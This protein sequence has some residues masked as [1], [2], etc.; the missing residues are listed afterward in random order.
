MNCQTKN[1]LSLVATV[2][3]VLSPLALD[4]GWQDKGAYQKKYSPRQFK[5]S[6]IVPQKLAAS[7][8]SKKQMHHFVKT[9]KQK[10]ESSAP[11]QVTRWEPRLC[12]KDPA[13]VCLMGFLLLSAMT[14]AYQEIHCPPKHAVQLPSAQEIAR[15][16]GAAG[17]KRFAYMSDLPKM[18]GNKKV[19]GC[20]LWNAF[21]NAKYP[22]V[23]KFESSPVRSL[24]MSYCEWLA[25]LF[26]PE[27]TIIPAILGKA[28]KPRQER[29]VARF[30]QEHGL[31]CQK[32]NATGQY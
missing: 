5:Q 9:Q 30:V 25:L 2:L 22:Y 17:F 32:L 16:I 28:R 31:V 6:Q 14:R 21:T 1:L 18:L 3:L 7:F 29:S 19:K 12:I 24:Q 13:V 26:I 27:D 4:A 23:K 8:V 15:R 20:E 11:E 10:T